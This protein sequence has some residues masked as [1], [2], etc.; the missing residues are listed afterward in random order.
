M[1]PQEL[2]REGRVEE[3]VQILAADLRA[4]PSNLQKRTFLFE[5]LC[6]LGEYDRARKQLDILSSENKDS[7]LGALTYQAA[8]NGETLRCEMFEAKKFPVA[9]SNGSPLRGTINGKPFMSITDADGRVGER[10]EVYAAGD[11]LLISFH[12]IARL[13]IEAPKRLR[14]LLWSPAKLTTGPTFSNREMGEVFIPAL[15]P[16]SFQHPDGLVRLGRVTEWCEDESGE[17]APY[18]QKTL[19]VDGEEFPLLEIRTLEI[20]TPAS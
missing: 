9:A 17:Q 8:L 6:F 16:L 12:D 10:L 1:T 19:L 2:F 7:M 3:A 4:D 13:E 11:Y 20:E 14:D 15:Y 5:L 18:G